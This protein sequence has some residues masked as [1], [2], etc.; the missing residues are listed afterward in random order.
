MK[1]LPVLSVLL[2]ASQILTRP[3]GPVCPLAHHYPEPY[4]GSPLS[5]SAASH[6]V[7]EQHPEELCFCSSDMRLK[8]REQTPHWYFFT[9]AWVCR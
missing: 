1:L 4:M 2:V 8:V 3:A 6:A 9:S 5:L 7:G